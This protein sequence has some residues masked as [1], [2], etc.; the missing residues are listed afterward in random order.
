MTEQLT[1]EE[2]V[3]KVYPNAVICVATAKPYHLV[4]AKSHYHIETLG[5]HPDC[6]TEMETWQDALNQI[7][8]E[9][10]VKAV[11]PNV[12]MRYDTVW[13]GYHF[14]GLNRE[15]TP[16]YTTSMEAAWKS[17]ADKIREGKELEINW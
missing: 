1:P 9:V 10:L 3:K 14:V 17:A 4:I 5:G 12:T 13:G 15:H 7:P 11:Y 2:I 8:D 16:D 6:K